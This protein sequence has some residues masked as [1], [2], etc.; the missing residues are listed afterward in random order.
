FLSPLRFT[1]TESGKSESVKALTGGN[2]ITGAFWVAPAEGFDWRSSDAIALVEGQVDALAL[3]ACGIPTIAVGGGSLPVWIA[4]AVAFKAVAISSD[5]DTAGEKAAEKWS[6]QIATYTQRSFRL[7]PADGFKDFG[8]VMEEIGRSHLL[9]WLKDE[10][11]QLA[12]DITVHKDGAARI[13]EMMQGFP[14]LLRA[15][16]LGELPSETLYLPSP[17]G[18]VW[19]IEHAAAAII[20]IDRAWAQRARQ[21]QEAK[22]DLNVLEIESL[23][24]AGRFL[25]GAAAAWNGDTWLDAFVCL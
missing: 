17:F 7:R 24:M 5:N 19:S 11:P 23:E 3:A 8:E 21:C 18:D 25:D 2:Q 14:R 15:A 10:A 22:R 20:E 4:R 9:R 1:D 6:E 16:H 12:L 13:C